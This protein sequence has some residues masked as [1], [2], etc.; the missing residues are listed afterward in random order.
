MRQFLVHKQEEKG[1]SENDRTIYDG[2][3]RRKSSNFF[4]RVD[5]V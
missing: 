2:G 3:N 1:Y 4:R 5:D